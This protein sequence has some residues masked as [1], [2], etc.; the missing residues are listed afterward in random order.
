MAH[1]ILNGARLALPNSWGTFSNPVLDEDVSDLVSPLVAS[2]F[3][4]KSFL[5][6]FNLSAQ[7]FVGIDAFA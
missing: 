4:P 3:L 1:E 2:A 7:G 5:R 6:G